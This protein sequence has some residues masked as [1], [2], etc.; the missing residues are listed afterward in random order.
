MTRSAFKGHSF[1]Y[2]S[3]H[4]GLHVRIASAWC[5]DCN[6]FIEVLRIQ[7]HSS[8]ELAGAILLGHD[9]VVFKALLDL[10]SCSVAL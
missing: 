8:L 5:N 3:N 1:I 10:A 7:M 2:E 9:L 6:V 4:L